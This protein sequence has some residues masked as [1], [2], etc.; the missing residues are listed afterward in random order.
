MLKVG[1]PGGEVMVL[2]TTNQGQVRKAQ[3]ALEQV[4]IQARQND[5]NT[6]Q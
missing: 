2:S 4:V 5:S 3:E 1:T 6:T